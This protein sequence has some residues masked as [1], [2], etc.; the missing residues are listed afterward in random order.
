MIYK[1]VLS[2]P[3]VQEMTFYGSI[4][5]VESLS[6]QWLGRFQPSFNDGSFMDDRGGSEFFATPCEL[7]EGQTLTPDDFEL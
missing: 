5:L 3:P 6:Q 4:A 2:F 7:P 1:I